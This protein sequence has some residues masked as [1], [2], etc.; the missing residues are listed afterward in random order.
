[1]V[2]V[3]DGSPDFLKYLDKQG[4]S[5]GTTLLI[6][7][8]QNFDQSLLLQVNGKKELYLSHE[9]SKKIFVE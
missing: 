5:L 7:E 4:I 2:T 1:M 8:V 6:Q 9:A 3:E